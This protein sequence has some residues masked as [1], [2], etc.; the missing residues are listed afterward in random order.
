MIVFR[1]VTCRLCGREARPKTVF[2]SIS[3][4]HVK[5]ADSR[6]LVTYAL[7]CVVDYPGVVEV[8]V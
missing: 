7:E 5:F 4:S 3:V 2:I 8:I 6:R 1:P